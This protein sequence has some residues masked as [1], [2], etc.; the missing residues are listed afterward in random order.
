MDESMDGLRDEDINVEKLIR[1]EIINYR[2]S[3]AGDS[4]DKI[5]K[6]NALIIDVC[7]SKAIEIVEECFKS[8]EQSNN[9]KQ[10]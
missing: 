5:Y 3:L 1:S 2:N 10:N 8:T 9:R 4:N 7:F 6:Q